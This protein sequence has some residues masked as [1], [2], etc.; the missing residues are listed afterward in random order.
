MIAPII[1]LTIDCPAGYKDKFG[2]CVC[3]DDNA[4]TV[5]GSCQCKSGY[6]SL[7]G[8]CTPC[9]EGSS[10]DSGSCKCSDEDK[11]FD[12]TLGLCTCTGEKQVLVGDKCETCNEN[13]DDETKRCVCADQRFDWY[14]DP[15]C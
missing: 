5:D 4:E 13:F 6:F 3:A 2:K 8:S 15:S 9:P 11:E 12:P 1:A 7:N 10:G 14:E